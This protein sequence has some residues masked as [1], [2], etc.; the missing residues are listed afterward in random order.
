MSSSGLK[1]ESDPLR[2]SEKSVQLLGSHLNKI[3]RTDS[4]A[5]EVIGSVTGIIIGDQL[6]ADLNLQIEVVPAAERIAEQLGNWSV[7]FGIVS[8]YAE[9]SLGLV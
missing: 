7:P 1:F 4:R 6:P 2:L 5:R 8:R 3:P 9:R